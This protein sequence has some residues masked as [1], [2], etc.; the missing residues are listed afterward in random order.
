MMENV[1]GL[2]RE[3]RSAY[4]QLKNRLRKLGYQLMDDVLEVANF[5]VPQFRRRL[6]LVGGL[7]FN[8]DLPEPTHSR[9]GKAGLSCWK[10]VKD[11]IGHMQESIVLEEA[12][13]RG[14]V[15]QSDWHV[16]RKLSP[17]NVKRIQAAKSG[18]TWPS[19][20]EELR[21][22]CHQGDYTGS[23]DVVFPGRRMIIF[24]NGCFW[25]SHENCLRASLPKTRSQYWR[26]RIL[27]NQERDARSI[28]ALEKLG[29]VVG[30]VWECQTKDVISLKDRL[31]RFLDRE[32]YS[33]E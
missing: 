22:R 9:D 1:P 26:G 21:P 3:G 4:R 31:V 29:W 25:H 24:V 13:K 8:I 19:I 33:I 10:T 23:P 12:R 20:P 27:K 2:T 7:D 6:V 30:T 5:G 32:A 11:A 15:R 28:S 18:K 17:K 14:D 16:V